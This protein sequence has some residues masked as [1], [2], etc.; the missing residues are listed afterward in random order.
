MSVL[1]CVCVFV[2]FGVVRTTLGES[3]VLYAT[4]VVRDELGVEG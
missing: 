2:F 1:C 4:F 3:V